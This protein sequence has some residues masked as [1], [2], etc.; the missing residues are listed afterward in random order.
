MVAQVLRHG[1]AA[2]EHLLDARMRDVA[3]DDE[4]P[5]QGDARLHG[6]CGEL[7]PDVVHGLGEVD[8]YDVAVVLV[9]DIREVVRGIALELLEEGTLRCDARECLAVRRAR[10]G[11][12]DRQRGAMAGKSDDAH[13]VAEVLAAKLRPDAEAAGEIE[14]LCLHLEVAEAMCVHASVHGKGV[15]VASARQLGH[16][17]GV[18]RAGAAD[19]DRQVVRRACRGAQRAQ[20]GVEEL[21]EARG[22]EQRLGLLEE[23]GLVGRPAALGHIEQ[24]VGELVPRLGVGVDLDLRREIGAGIALIPHGERRHLGVAEVEHGEG[25]VD[26]SADRLFIGALGEHLL[27]ALADDDGGAG[28]L[29][30]REH[31]AR[32]DVGVL[33]QVEGNELVV[34][35]R[36]GVVD[37]RAQLGEVARPQQVRDI[38]D[39]LHG[40]QAQDLGLD[41]EEGAITQL[42]RAHAVAGDQ[43]VRR[44]VRPQRQRV[45]VG[46]LGHGTSL[47]G[48]ASVG[49]AP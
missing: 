17:E 30:H 6:Q 34:G 48:G 43:A 2:I 49:S 45:D 40:E 25:V 38:A 20:R 7:P 14:D 5:G 35:A 29:A 41:L 3:R 37:D 23:E 10:D 46:E 4:G 31:P 28:V 15:E 11:D 13:V 19:H 44:R 33:E 39:R 1:L 42:Y 32:G 24:F 47:G 16:L 26:A 27:A 22:V 18:L 9:L 21:P 8:A 12:G 36:L